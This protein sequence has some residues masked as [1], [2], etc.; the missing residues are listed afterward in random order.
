M[1]TAR[2]NQLARTLA[3]LDRL[4]AGLRS[5]LISLVLGRIVPFVGTAGLRFEEISAQ[6]V[7]VVVRNRRPVRNHI[8]GV[9]AA[10][11]ALL[12]ETATGFAVG[13]HLPDDKLPLIKSLKVDYLKR[14]QGD[15]RAVAQLS[16]DQI[17]QV[18]D[19]PK[20]EVTVPVAISDDA[21]TE[22]I[23]CE[24]VWAWV[25]KQRA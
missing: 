15:L 2:P 8:R 4:P 23:Q 5:P 6:R 16:A 25:P 10:A 9:H 18:Q 12:A 1:S 3:R 17:R 13:L 14:A 20:G 7:V 11:M 19:Q 21:G 22:P 24:M